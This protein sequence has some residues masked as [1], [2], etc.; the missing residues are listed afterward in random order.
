M[1][2]QKQARQA[3]VNIG[4]VGHVDH[5]KT[6]LV[7]AL[8]GEWTDRHS[9]EITR[10][11]T[12]RLGYADADFY[13]CDECNGSE[14]YSIKDVCAQN[15]K[16]KLLR[17]VSFVDCP[18]H[19]T[20]MAI[21]M[22]GAS[23]MDGALLVIAA[24]EDCPQPQTREHLYALNISEIKNI[25]IVQ[26]KIDL[27]TKEQALKNYNQIK[28]FLKG[29]IAEN[30]TIIPVAAHYG[31]N[32]DLL[33]EAIQTYIPTPKRDENKP[34]KML[35]ARSFDINKP[36]QD[37]SKII[38]GVV[39]GSIIQGTVKIGDEVEIRPGVAVKD[40]YVPVKTKVASI[41]ASRGSLDIGR[42]GGLIA[43]GTQLD[44]FLTKGNSM[45]GNV[46]G[47]PDTLPQSLKEIVIATSL[48]KETVGLGKVT[49]IIRGELLV[50][51]AGTSTTL[52]NVI[53]TKKGRAKLV[54][55]KPIC[56]DKGGKVVLSRRASTRWCLI[57]YGV[58]E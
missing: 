23:L 1:K 39:G 45:I 21:M 10:G 36:S 29:S 26:N 34:L 20:L 25:I 47:K 12:M 51:N 5:G 14:G 28:E 33:I 24:N 13:K 44:P 52:G 17:T 27:V 46:V 42:P 38:G 49:D 8:T 2:S 41:Q 6:S 22:S 4:I 40:N 7:K 16:A 35:V 19:E 53:E 57:G 18:G 31:V 43:L 55:K 50:V 30:A 37:V 11:I 48:L 15:H 54:L 58:I 9:E 56:I 32:L 3:E